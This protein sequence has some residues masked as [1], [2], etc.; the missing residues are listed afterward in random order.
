VL[1]PIHRSN[2]DF[3]LAALPT[4]RRVRFMAKHTIFKEGRAE[5]ALLALGA[6]PVR[7]GTPDRA[8]FRQCEELL[9]AGELVVM[10]PEG[11][12]C[13]GDTIHPFFRGPAFMACRQ[14]VPIVPMGIGGSERAMPRGARMIRPTKIVITVGEP[15][16]PDVE[17]EGRISRT[18]TDAL[19]GQLAVEVQRLFDDARSRSGG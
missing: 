10:F 15:I 19:T 7:R 5:R 14:R 3:L 6:F 4:R 12:R 9:A 13:T 17:L 1:A 11:T 18:Q 16:Y 8:A 2:L